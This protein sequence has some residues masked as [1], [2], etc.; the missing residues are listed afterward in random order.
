[1]EP[2]FSAFRIANDAKFF[3]AN[4]E[5]SDSSD[6]ADMQAGLSYLWVHVS[7]GTFSHVSGQMTNIFL[8]VDTCGVDVKTIFQ[9][10]HRQIIILPY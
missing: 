1:M 10:H 5:D 8:K 3:H 4:N 2:S 9:T 6:S 7:E